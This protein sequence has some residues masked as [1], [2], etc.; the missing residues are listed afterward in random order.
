MSENINAVWS[1]IVKNEN[2]TFKTVRGIPYSYKV[3]D[4]FILINNDPKRRITKEHI[5]RALLIENPSPSKINL[6][7]I[8]GPSYV[9]GIITDVRV[10][11]QS[12]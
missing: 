12:I 2:Q 11:M 5:A 7:N 8:W 3:M 6:A 9:Y 10:K 1:N 4:D